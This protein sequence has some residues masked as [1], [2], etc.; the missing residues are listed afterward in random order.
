VFHICSISAM[1]ELPDPPSGFVPVPLRYRRDGWT[2][3]RQYSYLLALAETG[4]SRSAAKAVGM[5][6]QSARKL[7]RRPEAAL[8][9]RL[10]IAAVNCGRQR[11]FA[12]RRPARRPAPSRGRC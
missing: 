2:P 5:T 12:E 11:R 8:F 9:D 3:A 4:R 1:A 10:C 7:R 6:E